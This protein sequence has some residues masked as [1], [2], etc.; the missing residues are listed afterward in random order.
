MSDE[1]GFG[2]PLLNDWVRQHGPDARLVQ[3]LEAASHRPFNGAFTTTSLLYG[4]ATTTPELLGGVAN[5]LPVANR[6]PEHPASQA[7]FASHNTIDVLN[8]TAEVAARFG[9]AAPTAADLLATLIAPPPPHGEETSAR[10]YLRSVGLLS[11]ATDALLAWVA[12]HEQ[13]HSNAMRGFLAVGVL[14]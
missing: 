5:V 1:A 12:R 3:I 2:I 11:P 13:D 10:K 7:N 6:A 4:I 14:P 9:R 8:K